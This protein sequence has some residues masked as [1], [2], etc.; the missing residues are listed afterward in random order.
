MAL[1]FEVNKVLDIFDK[2]GQKTLFSGSL[3]TVLTWIQSD[4]RIIDI[5]EA[6]YLLGTAAAESDYSLQRWEADYVCGPAGVPY[7]S[8]GPCQDALNYYRS[9]KGGK[10]NYYN[11]GLDKRGLPYFGRGLIQLTGKDNY[12]K[13]GEILGIDLLGNPD[14]ALNQRYS[15]DIAVEYMS[16]IKKPYK[17]T[18][19]GYAREG[20]LEKARRTINGG[21]INIDEINKKYNLW[22][23]IFKEAGG[24][25]NTT[26]AIVINSETNQRIAIEYKFIPGEDVTDVS[27]LPVDVIN[28]PTEGF[29][30]PV[31]EIN[32]TNQSSISPSNGSN[33]NLN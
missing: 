20:N 22:L 7:S 30:L 32:I 28:D 5:K 29:P 10:Q 26:Q 17:S 23:S 1:L 14:L 31:D 2:K 11:L 19:F 21:T 18:T 8:K 12:K 33:M 16:R 13:Y 4:N 3:F 25:L 15:Y 6:A 24:F 9:T 27:P